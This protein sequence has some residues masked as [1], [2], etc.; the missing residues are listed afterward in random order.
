[1]FGQVLHYIHWRS[2]DHVARYYWWP[3]SLPRTA[4][5]KWETK[6]VDNVRRGRHGKH[7]QKSMEML[8]VE[9][10]C[11]LTNESHESFGSQSWR[12][13]CR[14]G[15]NL[16]RLWRLSFNVKMGGHQN[17]SEYHHYHVEIKLCAK[18][19]A[20]VEDCTRSESV[21][22]AFSLH[23]SRSFPPRGPLAMLAFHRFSRPWIGRSETIYPNRLLLFRQDS[24]SYQR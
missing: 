9:V 20:V 17:T 23:I 3:P 7:N 18:A 16:S 12:Q 11:G 4:E 14:F 6:A 15:R 19:R 2:H 10:I 13:N 8:Q 1:M 5:I 22:I 24:N 21:A